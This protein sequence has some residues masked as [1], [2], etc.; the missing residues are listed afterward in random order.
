MKWLNLVIS[1]FIQTVNIIIWI[2]LWKNIN[3]LDIIS[4]KY[5]SENWLKKNGKFMI[6]DSSSTACSPVM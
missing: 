3:E 5:C 6:M 1:F 4:Y 2:D